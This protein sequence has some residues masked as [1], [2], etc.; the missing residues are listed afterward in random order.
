MSPDG[1]HLAMIAAADKH[2]PAAGRLMVGSAETGEF[3]DVLPDYVG[4]V[5]DLAWV[6]ADTVA[7][8]G[9]EGT[10]TVIGTVNADGSGLSVTPDRR[11][12]RHLVLDRPERPDRP[13]SSASRRGIPARSS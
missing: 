4:H 12:D 9:D 8:V 2:D 3:R 6:D 13:P 10:G 11:P 7:F 5:A 1:K